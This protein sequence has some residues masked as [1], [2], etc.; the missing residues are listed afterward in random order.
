MQGVLIDDH[1]I[2]VDFSQSVSRL[3]NLWRDSANSKRSHKG[4]FGGISGLEK[5]SHYRE[6]DGRT[7][8]RN[9]RMVFDRNEA[10]K[11]KWE[12]KRASQI[13]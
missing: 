13:T 3:S 4:G 1:R 12:G 6:D 2:H 10:K 9:Y 5:K 8:G 7:S 11:S